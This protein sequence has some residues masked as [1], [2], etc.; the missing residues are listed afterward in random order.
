MTCSVCKKE[1]N[2]KKIK[3]VIIY[4]AHYVYDNELFCELCFFKNKKNINNKKFD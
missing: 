1:L 4:E 3:K 2:S